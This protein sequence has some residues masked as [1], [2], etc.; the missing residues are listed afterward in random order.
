ML[1]LPFFQITAHENTFSLATEMTQLFWL[2]RLYCCL[3][4]PSGL[5]YDESK[6][7]F[8]Y[9]DFLIVGSNTFRC[10]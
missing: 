8:Y 10:R 1:S 9:V 7:Q 4:L 6:K 2:N 3:M 5:T